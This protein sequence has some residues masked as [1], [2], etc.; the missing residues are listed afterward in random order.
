[1]K[2]IFSFSFSSSNSN[3]VNHGIIFLSVSKSSQHLHLLFV[4]FSSRPTKKK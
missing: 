3:L 4:D 1:P 2:K